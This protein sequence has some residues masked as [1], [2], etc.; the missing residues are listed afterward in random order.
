V[1]QAL[2]ENRFATRTGAVT[3]I[4]FV[5]MAIAESAAEVCV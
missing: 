3:V 4:A 5:G 2:V 1:P